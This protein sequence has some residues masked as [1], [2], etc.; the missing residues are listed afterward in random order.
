MTKRKMGAL[1]AMYPMPTTLVGAV[2]NNKPNF[3]TIAHVG[4]C[5]VGQPECVSFGIN[6]SHYTNQGIHEHKEFSVNLPGENLVL[7]TDYCGLVSGKNT[8]KSGLFELYRGELEHAP[9][10]AAC[11]VAMECR[12]YDVIDFPRHELFIG[13]IIQTH[14]DESVLSGDKVDVAKVRPLLFDMSGKRYWSLGKDLA[15][16]WNE[17]LKLKRE[18]EGKG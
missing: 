13:E 1:N 17:G 16:C 15:G 3:I 10:I 14:V 7:E 5:T 8:D 11:P 18:L 9:L 6:K 12:L 2:V 4:I